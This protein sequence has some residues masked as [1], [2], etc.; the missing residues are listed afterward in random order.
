M[1]QGYGFLAVFVSAVAFRSVER[2]NAYHER[3]H[4][5]VEQLERLMLM[6]LLVLFGGAVSVGGLLDELTW[7]AVLFALLTIFLVR[8][9]IAWISL[10][11]S[12]RPFD[13]KAVIAVFGIRGVGSFY[14]LAYGLGH[15]SFERPGLLWSALGLVVLISVLL[16]GSTVTPVMRVLDG[17]RK[18]VAP[19]SGSA[20]EP[21][22]P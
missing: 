10:V 3:L 4:N 20:F 12:S 1:A 18:R 17:R 8:P 19:A 15:A 9:L 13:E 7:S 11:G 16:H 22:Q 21:L 14:Y 6:I 5:F 2:H